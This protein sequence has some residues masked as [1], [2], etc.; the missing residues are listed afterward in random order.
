V[1]KGWGEAYP[2]LTVNGVPLERGEGYRLG[3][4]RTLEDTDLVV[5]VETETV[6]PMTL[7]LRPE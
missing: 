7:S 5:W 4:V 1:I 6:K 2:K 3:H